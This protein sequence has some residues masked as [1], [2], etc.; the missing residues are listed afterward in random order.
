MTLKLDHIA[1]SAPT[2]EAGMAFV[3]DRLGVQI[4][5]GGEHPKMGTH[6]C[7]M[8]LGA[9]IYLE[10]IAVNPQAAPLEHA[11]W[12]ALDERG[13]QPP[14]LGTWVI[15]ADNIDTAIAHMTPDVG[16]A[17]P[18]SRGDLHWKITVPTDGSMPYNGC[19]PTVIEWPGGISP[20]HKIDDLGCDLLELLIEHP[21][22]EQIKAS[23]G[24][25]Q[26]DPRLVFKAA[27]QARLTARIKTP[28]GIVSL[29]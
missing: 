12:F 6:N 10:V 7:L 5:L 2:L 28:S 16:P 22:I 15:R 11:R 19:H 23:L 4:P 3:K 21:E 26:I 29:S 9:D 27:D 25:E 13:T 1:I 18:M 20:A 24:D 14:F 17:I 8:R